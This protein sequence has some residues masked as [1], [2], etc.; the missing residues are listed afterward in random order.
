M[1]D[2]TKNA[3]LWDA[4]ARLVGYNELARNARTVGEKMYLRLARDEAQKV[5]E[6]LGGKIDLK[7]TP[8]EIVVQT[9]PPFIALDAEDI[10]LMREAIRAYEARD[11]R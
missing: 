11:R 5:Y 9:S 2:M 3:E 6:S 4:L 10:D 1:S 7:A 8:P